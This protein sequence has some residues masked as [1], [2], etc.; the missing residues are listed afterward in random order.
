MTRLADLELLLRTAELGSLTAAARAL[1]WSPAAASAAV[2]RM[3]ADWGAPVFVRSTRSLRLSPEGERM[4]PHVR[5]ALD[6][7]T[8]ARAAAGNTRTALAGELQIALPSD[9]GRHVVLPWLDAF[10]REHPALA[11]RLHLSDRN[12]DLLRAPIDVALRYGE[13]PSSAQVALPLVPGNRRVLVAAPDYVARHGIPATPAALEQREALRFML[14]DRLPA[15]WKLQ[16]NGEWT[17]I[18]IRGSRSSNDGEVVKRWAV[19]GLGIAYKSWLDVAAEIATGELLHIN[20]H[21]G[22]EPAPLNLV[23]T[24]RKQL[25]AAVRALH[26]HLLREF[27]LLQPLPT[28]VQALAPTATQRAGAAKR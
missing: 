28:L 3:E 27:A 18:D 14:G 16:I 10:Q 19:A 21:W 23:V 17:S 8:A 13:P 9:L 26:A 4:L 6:S 20:A 5:A 25:N 12:S 11:L 7:M 24:G 15:A 2:K 22:G 1:D